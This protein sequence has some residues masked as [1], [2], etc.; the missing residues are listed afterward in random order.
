MFLLKKV[1]QE[2]GSDQD[3]GA[4][5]RKTL[6]HNPII[7]SLL[8]NDSISKESTQEKKAYLHDKKTFELT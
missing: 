5:K 8:I 2:R 4:E 7:L 6:R 3:G 1:Y